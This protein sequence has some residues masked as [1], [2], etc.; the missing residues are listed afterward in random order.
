MTTRVAFLRAVNVGQRKVKMSRLVEIFEQ[1]G[2][3]NVWTYI[4]SGNIV[5]DAPGTRAALEKKIGAAVEAEYGFEATTFVR[6]A[7]ELSKILSATPFKVGAKDTYFVTFLKDTPSAATAKELESFSN[8]MD[9]L[10]VSGRDIHW[11]MHG[12]SMETTLKKKHWNIFGPN[13]STSRNVNMLR[14]LDAKLEE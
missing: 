6:T 3:E 12:T 11:R 4:N 5:F 7:S 2:Y 13:S 8:D 1:L 9:T 10:V 14:K